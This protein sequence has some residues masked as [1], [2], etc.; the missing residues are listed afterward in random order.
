MQGYNRPFFSSCKAVVSLQWIHS[1]SPTLAGST[2]EKGVV[3]VK[4]LSSKTIWGTCWWLTPCFV[5]RGLF[6]GIWSFSL[7]WVKRSVTLSVLPDKSA[8]VLYSSRQP[9]EMGEY[10]YLCYRGRG[11]LRHRK[12]WVKWQCTLVAELLYFSCTVEARVSFRAIS[13]LQEVSY[14]ICP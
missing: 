7:T 8:W 6:L 12:I 14:S 1:V 3:L 9:S 13:A 2:Q 4:W 11:K 10:C 5:S